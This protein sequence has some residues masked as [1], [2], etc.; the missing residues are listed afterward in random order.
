M[1][2]TGRK[3]KNCLPKNANGWLIKCRSI[4]VRSMRCSMMNAKGFGSGTRN[5]MKP[6]LVIMCNISSGSSASLV[7]SFSAWLSSCYSIAIT[8]GRSNLLF[9][10]WLVGFILGS[11]SPLT[12]GISA[13]NQWVCLFGCQSW[14]DYIEWLGKLIFSGLGVWNKYNVPKVFKQKIAR[15]ESVKFFRTDSIKMVKNHKFGEN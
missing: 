10:T 15:M 8:T 9:P 11:T 2:L 7:S 13:E 3:S 14:Y 12:I 5:T 4:F 6:I 1:M